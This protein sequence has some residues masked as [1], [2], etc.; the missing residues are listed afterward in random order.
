M[1]SCRTAFRTAGAFFIALLAVPACALA[2]TPPGLDAPAAG[3][4]SFKEGGGMKFEWH[5]TLQGDADTLNRSF[6][7]LE[8]VKASD[9]PSGA[10]SE[11]TNVENFQSTEPGKTVTEL[12]LGVPNAG[13][14]RWRVCAWGV[15]DDIVAN[16]IV[17]LPGGCSASRAFETSAAAVDNRTPG[18]LKMEERVQVPGR[19]ET[20]VVTRPDP[21]Q[22]V[23]TTPVAPP[24]DTAPEPAKPEVETP[25]PTSFTKLLEGADLLGKGSSVGGLDGSEASPLAAEQASTREG[26]GGSI[27][28]GLTMT[29]PLVPIPFWTL[30]L[31]LACIPV[32]KL[33]RTDV[34]AMFDWADGSIDG[35][36]SL[37]YV[38]GDLATVPVANEFKPRMTTADADAPALV[39]TSSSAPER[40]RQAA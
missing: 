27:M 3:A 22:Q 9:M 33:W 35:S 2:A 36:G 32:A 5:G 1:L 20:V 28:N 21:N 8:I 37:D 23:E 29:L 13:T 30:A 19:V 6:F 10:Q 31:L 11:W 16:E 15:V 12:E 26:I 40:G 38:D 14:Y 7:R 34:L 24:K 39:G 25:L 17:Q 4:S 18:E